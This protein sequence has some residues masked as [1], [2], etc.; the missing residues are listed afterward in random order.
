MRV[1][2][3]LEAMDTHRIDGKTI[4]ETMKECSDEGWTFEL[5][6][7]FLMQWYLEGTIAEVL[8]EYIKLNWR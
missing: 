5:F 7:D 6:H 2:L 3:T 4:A 8:S 1:A